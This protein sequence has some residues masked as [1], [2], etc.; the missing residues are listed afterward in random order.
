MAH[1]FWG[2][3]VTPGSWSEMWL[4]EG[5]VTF[6]TAAWKEHRWGRAAFDREMSLAERRVTM[7]ADAG[8]GKPLAW[9][10][11]Y[12]SLR[13]RRAIAYSRGALFMNLLRKRLGEDTFWR[14]LRT[15]TTTFGEQSVTSRDFQRAFERSSGENLAPLF[16]Q[17]VFDGPVTTNAPSR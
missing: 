14:A 11:D 6:M 15:Y 16:R 7:A 4:S 9:P 1:Q 12:P 2:N 5:V 8:Y 10:G 13:M 3:S 17:W